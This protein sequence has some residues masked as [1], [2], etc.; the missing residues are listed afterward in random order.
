MELT[1]TMRLRIVAAGCTGAVLIGV[2]GWAL[3]APDEPLGVVYLGTIG[4]GEASALAALAFLAGLTAYFASWPYGRQ[5]GILAVPVGLAV[6]GLRSG[7]M[8]D[9]LTL[10]APLDARL[11]ILSA[12]RWEPLFWLAIVG[13]GVAGVLVAEKIHSGV[14]V[15]VGQPEANSKQNKYLNAAIAVVGSVLVAQLCVRI[16]VQDIRASAGQWGAVV[17]QPAPGQIAFGVIMSFGVAAFAA[18]RFLAVSYLWPALSS[19]LVTAFA[20]STYAKPDLLERIF[21]TWPSRFF[22]NSILSILPLQMVAFGVLGSVAGYWLA[23]R[24]SCW[25][26][27]S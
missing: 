27:H 20:I 6:W 3:G 22:T 26:E 5:I 16:F 7:S 13:V 11:R 15:A 25:R 8:A 12:L 9:L 10:N 23:V 24:Y 2:L 19:S 21:T 17:G 18:K 1:W 14:K 4:I